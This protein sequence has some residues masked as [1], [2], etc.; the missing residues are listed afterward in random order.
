MARPQPS[1]RDPQDDAQARAWAEEA[2]RRGEAG[3][4]KDDSA[5]LA[6]KLA[7]EKRKLK[8]R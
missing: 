1:E 6:R 8:R 2:R 7:E 4:L 5:Y 3:E